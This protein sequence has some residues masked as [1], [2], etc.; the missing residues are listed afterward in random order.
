[1]L[2]P[3]QQKDQKIKQ[4]QKTERKAFWTLAVTS[5]C[6]ICIFSLSRHPDAIGRSLPRRRQRP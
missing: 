5:Q 2:V 1:M 3:S 4:I 6:R